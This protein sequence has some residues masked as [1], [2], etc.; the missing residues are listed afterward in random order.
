ME[1]QTY[2]K[3]TS[4]HNRHSREKLTLLRYAQ[5]K[6]GGSAKWEY[7]RRA[8]A[9]T[10]WSFGRDENALGDYAWYADN[11]RIDGEP[12]PSQQT[13]PTAPPSRST[14]T[15]RRTGKRSA[16]DTSPMRT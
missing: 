11:N 14:K 13:Q 6:R 8:G 4:L 10:T 7:A 3:P 1:C 16:Q 12:A 15:T 9:Q 5:R 2:E